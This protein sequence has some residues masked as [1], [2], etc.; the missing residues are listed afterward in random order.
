MKR[1]LALLI[2]AIALCLTSSLTAQTS[3][4]FILPDAAGHAKLV[5]VGLALYERANKALTRFHEEPRL[6]PLLEIWKRDS[7]P[8]VA[9]GTDPAN[10]GVLIQQMLRPT[11]PTTASS[12]RTP[13]LFVVINT[14][15][16]LPKGLRLYAEKNFSE[17]RVET[18][19]IYWFTHPISD[20][21]LSAGL[22]YFLQIRIENKAGRSHPETLLSAYESETRALDYLTGRKFSA[23][24]KTMIGLPA[25]DMAPGSIRLIEKEMLKMDALFGPSESSQELRFRFTTYNVLANLAKFSTR[26]KKLAY[27]ERL[28]ASLIKQ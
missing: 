25:P 9:I 22:V 15:L 23:L 6:A 17:F 24:A 14:D 19:H 7:I 10:G 16:Q 3:S 13:F 12:P 18:G 1:K 20:E 26:A 27:M 4:P 28:A 21:W 8:G 5:S 11:D 2:V